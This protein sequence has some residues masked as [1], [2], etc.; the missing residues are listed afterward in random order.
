MPSSRVFG[1]ERKYTHIATAYPWD[2]IALDEK[3]LYATPGSFDWVIPIKL[4]I[5]KEEYNKNKQIREL[6]YEPNKMDKILEIIT[7]GDFTNDELSNVGLTK[8]YVVYW[9]KT[10]DPSFTKLI[11][12]YDGRFYY[13][14]FVEAKDKNLL[15]QVHKY[16]EP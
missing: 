11:S 1:E 3:T 13:K 8:R 9:L 12:K 2:G 16:F 7:D 5:W 14:V 15:Q 6:F 10:D 4:Q